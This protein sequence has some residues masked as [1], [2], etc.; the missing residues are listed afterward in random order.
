MT[1]SPSATPVEPDASNSETILG[2]TVGPVPAAVRQRYGL[3][4]EQ[5]GV[6]ITAVEAR[7]PA[8]R[9]GAAAGVLIE[10]V[11]YDRVST[12]AEFKA[13]IEAARAAGRPSVL[14]AVRAATGQQGRIIVP[15]AAAE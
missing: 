1:E 12:V 7:S 9:E 6:L 3:T 14:L 4:A 8:A 5:S 11:N 13:A 15:F 2:M 10:R